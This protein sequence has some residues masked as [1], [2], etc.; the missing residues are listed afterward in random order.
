MWISEEVAAVQNHVP[1][2]IDDFTGDGVLDVLWL[3]M[4]RRANTWIVEALGEE[5]KS[6]EPFEFDEWKTLLG[7]GD[8]DG[9]GQ[10]D[11]LTEFIRDQ[12]EGSKGLAL[13]SKRAGDR[14]ES[15]GVIR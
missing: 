2:A 7:V 11:F 14:V 10:V 12:V 1:G 15:G 9:D 13:Q 6:G 8:F 5:F 4:F 3:P